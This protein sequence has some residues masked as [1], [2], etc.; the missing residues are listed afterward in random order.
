MK[1]ILGCCSSFKKCS[2]AGKCVHETDTRL[3]GILDYEE[4]LYKENIDK[5]LNF[6]TEYNENNRARAE[7]YKAKT[8]DNTKEALSIS[9]QNRHGNKTYIE[10][11]NRLF[12]IGKR[13]NYNGYTYSLSEDEG[14]Q[15]TAEIK[16]YG[17][18]CTDI[19]DQDKFMD[20][21]IENGELCN[22][23]IVITLDKQKYNIA[24]YNDRGLKMGTAVK[25][26][27]FMIKNKIDAEIEEIKNF[28][29]GKIL[30]NLKQTEEKAINNEKIQK[31]K[32]NYGQISFFDI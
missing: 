32:P 4:C 9:I 7:E 23:K 31:G 20:E 24:N 19:E 3:H 18:F 14:K 17:V 8:R 12:S 2:D 21:I 1:K 6:Y 30:K 16:K 11:P 28:S 15:L 22:C 10:V 27:S 29:G 26:A 25:V 13:S 5:G